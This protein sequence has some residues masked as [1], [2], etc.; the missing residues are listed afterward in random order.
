MQTFNLESS[1]HEVTPGVRDFA[2]QCIR[3]AGQ[4]SDAGHRQILME[5]AQQWM[6]AA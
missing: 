1:R 2:L 3:W 6:R 4:I 5:T